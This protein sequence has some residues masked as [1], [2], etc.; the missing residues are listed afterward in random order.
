[1]P[2]LMSQLATP[3]ESFYEVTTNPNG[4]VS[5]RQEFYTEG[6]D[7]NYVVAGEATA[8]IR[9]A[10]SDFTRAMPNAADRARAQVRNTTAR[11]ANQFRMAG[12]AANRAARTETQRRSSLNQRVV[13]ILAQATGENIGNDPRGWWNFWR[14]FNE[15][16]KSTSR[17]TYTRRWERQVNYVIP[18]PPPPTRGECFAAGTLIWTKTGLRPIETLTAGILVLAKDLETGELDFR[19]VMATTKRQPSQLLRILVDGYVIVTTR[20][21]PFWV[22][23]RG[24]RMAKELSPGDRLQTLKG[25]ARI[26]EVTTDGVEAAYNL[27]VDGHSNYF[28][29][30]DGMLVHDNSPRRPERVRV[31]VHAMQ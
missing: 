17:P 15:Y 20:G 5:Y 4:A 9:A 1:M 13:G 31:G 24:W 10:T 3:V 23:G 18:P 27:V 7:A 11:F 30:P 6:P 2:L 29:G 25:I 26:D 14:R 16:E 22:P 19:P 8:R 21:H 12:L 28:A